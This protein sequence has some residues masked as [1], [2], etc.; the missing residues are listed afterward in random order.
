[1]K[2][3]RKPWRM[4]NR[5]EIAVPTES[6]AQDKAGSDLGTAKRRT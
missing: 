4:N 5:T 1:M 3:F 2:N 6:G